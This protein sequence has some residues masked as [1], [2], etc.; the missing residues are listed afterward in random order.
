MW[1]WLVFM[2][3]VISYANKWGECFNYFEEGGVSPRIGPLTAFLAFF[4]LPQNCHSTCGCAIQQLMYCREPVTRLKVHWESDRLPS[5][6]WL[7][8]TSLCPV[9][10]CCYILLMVV[11][12]PLPSCLTSIMPNNFFIGFIINNH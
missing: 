9:L 4:G 1:R 6:A 2:G 3:S 8:L 12:Y 11:P 10:S 5:Q 7:A